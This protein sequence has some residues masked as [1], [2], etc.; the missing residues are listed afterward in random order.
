ML[1]GFEIMPSRK[2]DPH[3]WG[4]YTMVAP[5]WRGPAASRWLARDEVAQRLVWVHRF[6]HDVDC[7]DVIERV[8]AR[9]VVEG[10]AA[11]QGIHTAYCSSANSPCPAVVSEFVAS[12]SIERALAAGLWRD[13]RQAL[14]CL[15]FASRAVERSVVHSALEVDSLGRVFVAFPATAV[16][17]LPQEPS[18]A[19]AELAAL[20][21]TMSASLATD[22]AID[23]VLDHA[24]NGA[25][26]SVLAFDQAL[27]L[28]GV[29][30]G[31][32]DLPAI[33]P[34]VSLDEHPL[35][36]AQL[37]QRAIDDAAFRTSSEAEALTA[38]LLRWLQRW[39]I[40]PNILALLALLEPARQALRERSVRDRAIDKV[41]LALLGPL[42][43]TWIPLHPAACTRSAVIAGARVTLCPMLWSELQPTASTTAAE[44]RFCVACA[45]A[46]TSVSGD[47]GE[48]H[49]LASDVCAFRKSQDR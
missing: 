22:P 40:D 16:G 11:L 2:D 39:P 34:A 28:A 17:S 38:P 48:P 43:P 26:R 31:G 33:C 6:E 8:I 44:A 19:A 32:A 25:F 18:V 49:V 41:V 46:V 7:S 3:R 42:E 9:P 23:A 10:A 35:A 45:R 5:Q 14:S 36:A 21:R 4:A 15:R 47:D 20:A 30:E 24:A 12:I 27:A 13:Q 29:P 1:P 37:A